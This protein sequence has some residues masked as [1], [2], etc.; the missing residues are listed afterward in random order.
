MHVETE[1]SDEVNQNT[2][3]GRAYKT[4]PK[5]ECPECGGE[6]MNLERLDLVVMGGQGEYLT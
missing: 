6:K 1:Q 3:A 4:I 5:L 2:V